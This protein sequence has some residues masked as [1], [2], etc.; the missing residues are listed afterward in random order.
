MKFHIIPDTGLGSPGFDDLLIETL[1][2][3]EDAREL[4]Y[5]DGGGLATIGIGTNIEDSNSHMAL[6]LQQLGIISSSDS[7]TTIISRVKDF[8]DIAKVNYATDLD[9]QNAL[10]AEAKN[11]GVTIFKLSDIQMEDVVINILFGEKIFD[12]FTPAIEQRSLYSDLDLWLFGVNLQYDISIPLDSLEHIAL[13]SLA[14]NSRREPSV[15]ILGEQVEG[16]NL[17][18]DKLRTALSDDDRAEAWYEI[19]YGSNRTDVPGVAKRRYFESELFGLYDD[20]I[21]TASDITQEDAE[22]IYRM[23]TNHQAKILSTEQLFGGGVGV[24]RI[25]R[26]NIEFK[27]FNESIVGTDIEVLSIENSLKIAADKLETIYVDSANN[28]NNNAVTSAEINA[29][30]IQINDDAGGTLTGNKRNG[31]VTGA[32]LM[33]KNDLLIGGA[34]DDILKGEGGNDVLQGNDGEDKLFGGLGNNYLAGGNGNDTYFIEGS[35]NNVAEDTGTADLIPTIDVESS[36][37]TYFIAGDGVVNI[38]DYADSDTY[39]IGVLD[40]LLIT[41]PE[42]FSGTATIN[43][44][45]DDLAS[46]SDIYT[47]IEIGSTG[48]VTIND[49]AGNDTYSITN[50]AGTIIIDDDAGADDYVFT[51][52]TGTAT[53]TDADI[54]GDR[55]FINGVAQNLIVNETG[56]D[57]NVWTART[58]EGGLLTYTQNSPLTITDSNGATV[59]IENFQDGDFGIQLRD[60]VEITTTLTILG[61]RAPIDVNPGIPGVQ[62][63][64]DALGNVITDINIVESRSDLLKGSN[65]NDKIIA[66]ELDDTVFGKGGDDVINGGAD[67]DRLNGDAGDDL[68]EGGTGTDILTGGFGNDQLFAD[69]QSDINTVFDSDEVEAGDSRDWLTGG[70][71]DDTLIGSTGQNVLSGGGGKDFIAA[72]AGDDFIF[73]DTDFTAQQFDWTVTT[74][75]NTNHFNP[76]TPLIEPFDADADTIYAGGGDDVV[77]AKGGDVIEAVC[78]YRSVVSSN[79]QMLRNYERMSTV[80]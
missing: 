8:K 49:V 19:R 34:G 53:I 57:S 50:S 45:G 66:G 33:E 36:Q 39:Q 75:N 3:S 59:V 28:P 29:L 7:N 11:Y 13:S 52:F 48:M 27:L 80:I 2:V 23:Y 71:G 41:V 77:F 40:D 43:D 56:V 26:A 5:L 69:S 72:G 79:R 46:S 31:F 25:D 54:T 18:G 63:G 17:I 37:D 35:G 65:G 20:G 15:I 68:I 14:Y 30:D 1:R 64:N 51:N 73:G 4:P 6:V 12:E 32:G 21:T 78:S 70:P 47:L 10:N 44:I 61:D 9:L 55:L 16:F 38:I 42:G 58:D 60:A 62:P 76:V 24:N 22:E 74:E 67:R